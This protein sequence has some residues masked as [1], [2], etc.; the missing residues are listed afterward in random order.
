MYLKNVGVRF[1]KSGL[2]TAVFI[3]N[4]T[5]TTNEYAFCLFF[6]TRISRSVIFLDIENFYY[7]YFCATRNKRSFKILIC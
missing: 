5:S 6:Y 2:K 7:H 4:W 1:H 3:V